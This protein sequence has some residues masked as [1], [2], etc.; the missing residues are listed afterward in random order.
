MILKNTL[1]SIEQFVCIILAA[2]GISLVYYFIFN[3]GGLPHLIGGSLFFVFSFFSFIILEA[4][5]TE[6]RRERRYPR[7]YRL[8]NLPDE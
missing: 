1:K 8:P 7:A 5:K 6:V 3:G 2:A 4:E